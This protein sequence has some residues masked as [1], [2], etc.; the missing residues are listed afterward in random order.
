MGINLADKGYNDVP[1]ANPG[2][3]T[4]LPAGGYVCRIINAELANSKAGNL[5]L[6]LFVDIAEGDFTGFFKTSTEKARK[7]NADKKWDNAGIY[8]QLVFD[9]SNRVSRFFKGLITCIENSNSNFK[10]NINN[11]EPSVLRGLFCGFV[12]AFEEYQRR[13]DSIAERTIIKFPKSSAANGIF[14]DSISSAFKYPI[15]SVIIILLTIFGFLHTS[16][17]FSNKSFA[18]PAK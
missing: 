4:P 11:F 14:F 17:A 6:I 12:F 5:M 1:A 3:F 8:R 7:F 2:E 10:I 13:D 15:I 18:F 9:S 16:F